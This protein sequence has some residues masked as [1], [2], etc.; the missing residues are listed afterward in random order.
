MFTV[1]AISNAHDYR[2]VISNVLVP[3]AQTMLL[4][5]QMI[6]GH[7]WRTGRVDAFCPKSHGFESRSSR[8]VGTLGKSLTHSCLWRLG[9]KLRHKIRAVLGVLL[10]RSG[11]EEDL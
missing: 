3:S 6:V 9:V 4:Q 8:H 10:S 5:H 2:S 1:S 11:L 7:V